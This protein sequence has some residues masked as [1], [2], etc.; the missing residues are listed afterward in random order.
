MR[1]VK[2]TQI[3]SLCYLSFCAP[4]PQISPNP[5][6]S[7]TNDDLSRPNSF[8]LSTTLQQYI[9]SDSPSH[10]LKIHGHILKSGYQPNKNIAIKLLILHLKSGFISYARQLL[11]DMPEPTLSAYNYLLNA[12]VR[13]D[14]VEEAFNL[15][16]QMC[17][18]NG[19]PD[20][21][22][23]SL[24]LKAWAA[25]PSSLV[26][27]DLGRQVHAQMLKY[28]GEED[29][30]VFATLIDSYV[31]SGRLD[32]ARRVFDLMSVKNAICSTSLISACA[33]A[34]LVDK[35]WEIFESMERDYSLK[36]RMEHYACMVD[37]L[38]RSGRIQQA[39][40]FI[41]K[42]PEKPNSDVWAALLSSC[43]L[44]GDLEIA[45]MAADELFQL[46][47]NGRPGSY[48]ALSDA[49]AEVGMW[50]SV[51]E[52]RELMKLRGISKDTGFSWTGTDDVLF[53]NTMNY[54]PLFLYLLCFP[55]VYALSDVKQHYEAIYSFGDSLADTG[56]FLRSGALAFPTIAKL[57][58]GETFFQHPT[59]RCSNGRLVVDFLAE[60]FGLPLVPPYLSLPKGQR[61]PHGVNF[62]V[63]GAT[64]LNPILFR[65][66]T[67]RSVLWT[68]DSLSVQ[69]GWFTSHKSSLCSTK[70]VVLLSSVGR[71]GF[72]SLA[73]FN[74]LGLCDLFSQISK[75]TNATDCTNFFK[76]SLFI[77]GEIGGND[78]NFRS[79]V[80]KDIN[81]I[82][83]LV[84]KVTE[85]IS[86]A[87]S[88]LIEEGASSILVPGNL[89][90]GCSAV[91]LTLFASPDKA[92]YDENGC[93][94]H[95]NA[96][97][98]YH[99]AQLKLTL[100]KLRV[101]YPEAKIMYGDYYTAALQFYHAPGHF[102]FRE[103]LV[104]C[105]GGGGPYNFNYSARCGH[106][107][108]SVCQDPSAYANWDGIHLTEAAYKHI[109][110]G[111]IHGPFSSPS[112]LT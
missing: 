59:G 15:V 104:A 21:F 65:D 33:Y 84:P 50:D 37:L 92:D 106:P 45:S 112:L 95:Y 64:A 91:Y 4:K 94:K 28:D 101:K 83:E 14:Q 69:L 10:G 61:A 48:V 44:H 98:R 43:T 16:R 26:T 31:K 74:K 54:F 63:A 107:G 6:G 12:Y 9:N 109:A 99:N 62:A 34:G 76:K 51:N 20:S 13:H 27:I 87:I 56:N 110:T 36:P 103:V 47:T 102:G 96:F 39:W 97:A 46:C 80:S 60:E 17:D 7:H 38:G 89:P 55:C 3:R 58:Y 57:P 2:V 52:V 88:M 23:H 68:N 66:Y 22:T 108:Y 71:I 41:K 93:L 100:D 53:G 11:E 24:I 29:M 82:T 77:V 5:I 67:Q 79:F 35:G 8:Y 86:G 1:T 73:F 32:Y 49:L 18:S 78:Y 111:L 72:G 42:M 30:V 90:V 19:K 25:V 40:E 105:C 85:A 81:L 70:Q 75:C